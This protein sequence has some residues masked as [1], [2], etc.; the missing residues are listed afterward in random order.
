MK[1]V[2][3][4]TVSTE[5]DPE[6]PP[7]YRAG[8]VKLAPLIGAVE[9]RRQRLR[10]RPRGERLP[11]SLRVRQRGVAARASRP[12]ALRRAGEDGELEEVLEPGDTVCFPPGPGG[13]HKVT[14][15][16]RSR[17]AS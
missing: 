1:P 12:S 16:A 11:V 17:S 6:D 7:G 10:P 15:A 2:N 5:N 14:N 3:V 9:H 13:A 8:A 4:F